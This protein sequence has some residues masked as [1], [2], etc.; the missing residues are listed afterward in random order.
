MP[1]DEIEFTSWQYKT[2]A[3][4]PRQYSQS[5]R[6]A[7]DFGELPKLRERLVEVGAVSS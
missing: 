2:E 7:P 3:G 4:R 5:L 1:L 6:E